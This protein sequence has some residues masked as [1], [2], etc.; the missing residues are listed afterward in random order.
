MMTHECDDLTLTVCLYHAWRLFLLF[1][2]CL[3]FSCLSAL[4][5]LRALRAFPLV[6][7]FAGGPFAVAVFDYFRFRLRRCTVCK[8][9]VR[10]WAPTQALT[11]IRPLSPDEPL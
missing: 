1:L 2:V 5:P 6:R 11:P 10:E 9:T 4:R 8:T 3:F 7:G